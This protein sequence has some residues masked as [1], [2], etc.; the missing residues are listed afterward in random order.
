MQFSAFDY[1]VFIVYILGIVGLG[2]WVSREK[3]DHKKDS[4]DY[5]LA[6]KSLPWWVIGSSLIAANISAEHVRFRI[7]CRISYC[8]I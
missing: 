7:R 2:L 6:G 8:V 5:F 4:K 3:K 1:G